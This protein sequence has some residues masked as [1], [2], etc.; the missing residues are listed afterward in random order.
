[1]N[2]RLISNVKKIVIT[3]KMFLVRVLGYS[4]QAHYNESM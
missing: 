4:P 1:M 2:A 3:N